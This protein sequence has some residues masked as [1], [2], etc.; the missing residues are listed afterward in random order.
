MARA[1]I[2]CE[3]GLVG[4]QLKLVVEGIGCIVAPLC[5]RSGTAV[6][7]VYKRGYPQDVEVRGYTDGES[8]NTV[9]RGLAL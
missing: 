2:L 7:T 6:R 1:V 3:K 5:W 9:R 4:K 8:S